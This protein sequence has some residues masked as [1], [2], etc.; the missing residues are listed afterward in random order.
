MKK[1]FCL[2]LSLT[3]LPLL[4]SCAN[5]PG[6]TENKKKNSVVED[7][8]GGTNVKGYTG[9]ADVIEGF[10]QGTPL[11][12]Y[13]RRVSG[14]S[15]IGSGSSAV[16]RVRGLANSLNADSEPLF[17]VNGSSVSGGFK[18]VSSMVVS[19]NIKSI[20]VLKDAA[21]TGIY[22]SRASNGVIVITLKS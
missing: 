21:S 6:Y 8:Y 4:F 22:G 15:V 7:G 2:A 18:T 10:Q 16:V 3:L 13:L 20:S 1:C 9:S 19:T 17:I 12:D 5:R 14:V 11:E